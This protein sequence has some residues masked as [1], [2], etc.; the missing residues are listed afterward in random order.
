MCSM[1]E[2]AVPSS[3]ALTRVIMSP[4][5]C[6]THCSSDSLS[7]ASF[8]SAIG[9]AVACALACREW[10]KTLHLHLKD[11]CLIHNV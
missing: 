9:A 2:D 7:C 6:A 5:R 8:A 11:V 1:G 3:R 4:T 10:Q